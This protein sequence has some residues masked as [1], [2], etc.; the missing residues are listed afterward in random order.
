[1]TEARGGESTQDPLEARAQLG[2]EV[3]DALA[4][5]ERRRDSGAGTRGEDEEV[6]QLGGLQELVEGHVLHEVVGEP[7]LPLEAEAVVELRPPQ[8][9]V[10]HHRLLP[11]PRQEPRDVH[12][13][14]GLALLGRRAGDEDDLALLVAAGEE[15]GRAEV[16]VGLGHEVGVVGLVAR[17]RGQ[18][19]EV[20]VAL[21]L[22][23]IAEGVVE[24]VAGE[25]E[26]H[27]EGEA[28]DEADE[29]DLP[30]RPARTG[31]RGGE[32]LS[33]TDTLLLRM[34]AAMSLSLSFCSSTS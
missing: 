27:A 23:G 32:A 11:R 16:L 20:E 31:V 9:A 10:E 18:E 2:E 17:H 22:L 34:L 8:V 24:I 30:L 13:G 26:A 5:E 4:G 1:M 6:R 28:Q 14:G 19:I 29:A 3:D 15:Q 21:D 25:H 33:T 12:E 7:G